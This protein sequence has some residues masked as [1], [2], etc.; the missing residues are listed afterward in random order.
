[1]E[2]IVRSRR[3]DLL[4]LLDF[5]QDIKLTEEQRED[6]RLAVADE[7]LETGLKEN[8]EP[9]QRG[10]LLDELITRLGHL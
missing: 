3:S 10:L 2:E 7:F 5:P 6:L 1:M 8:G 9:N 4:G